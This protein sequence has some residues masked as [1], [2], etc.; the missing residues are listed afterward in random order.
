MKKITKL[1][2]GLVTV[3]T[4]ALVV[5]GCG[6]DKASDSSEKKKETIVVGTGAGPKPYT[7]VDETDNKIK[8][9][10]I[11]L[12]RDIFKADKTYEV[13]FDKTEFASVLAGLDSDRYQIGANAFAKT[14]EREEKYYYSDAI[15]RN[16]LA[17]IVPKGSNIKTL[18]DI[19]GKS[20]EGEP[21]VSYTVIIEKYNEEHADKP[22]KLDYTEADIIQQFRDVESGKIDFKLE[23]AIVAKSQVKDQALNLDV[24]EIPADEVKERSAFSYY[25]FPKTEKGAEIRDAVNK[26]IQ[27]LYDEGTILKLSEKYFNGDYTTEPKGK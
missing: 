7:Y 23:S 6:K 3:A 12:L 22:V 17:L 27:E 10:D 19:A 5:T 20:T 2:L 4:L 1:T 18:A 16:P 13:K 9:F 8:G 21:A 26:R 15:Y 24:I 11:D 25:I 14:A